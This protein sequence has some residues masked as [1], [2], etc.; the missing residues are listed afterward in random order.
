L[1]CVGD[2]V[3]VTDTD[4]TLIYCS[5]RLERIFANP[6]SGLLGAKIYD[7]VAGEQRKALRS[8][9]EHVVDADATGHTELMADDGRPLGQVVLRRVAL[10]A[11]GNTVAN[12]ATRSALGAVWSFTAP[13]EDAPLRLSD[14]P[15][16]DAIGVC[17]VDAAGR[18]EFTN[19]PFDEMVGRAAG[20]LAGTAAIDLIHLREHRASK[21]LTLDRLLRRFDAR[22]DKRQVAFRRRDGN[23]FAGEVLL[24]RIEQNG[25]RKTLIVIHDLAERKRLEGEIV[26]AS[27]RERRR[28]GSDLHDGLGQE[29][30]GI[31]LL[32]RGFARQI[33]PGDE[34]V[35]GQLNGIIGL[36][37]HAVESTR[38]LT[39][40]LSPA[41]PTRED[42]VAALGSLAAWS[43]S[44]FGIQVHVRVAVPPDL[45]IEESHAAHL[46]LIAQEAILNAV[47]HG[48]AE[49][50][51]L[52][53]RAGEQ[54][55]SLTI[56]DN[57][58]G[59]P[60]EPKTS[61]G[62]GM[63]IMAYRA[64]MIGG[65]VH[66]KNRKSGG[67]RVRCFYAQTPRKPKAAKLAR[68]RTPVATS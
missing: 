33:R 52:S 30:T 28:L 67:T 41:T 40:G 45:R 60:P 53:F 3:A 14:W 34:S 51:D 44:N 46:Y 11:Q 27:S 7:L 26:E 35:L 66:F 13:T 43:R 59:L 25:T 17:L 64:G 58:I 18:I 63:K 32:L 39:L 37:N 19:P 50:I 23:L 49:A 20:E 2:G 15:Q 57:G 48:R 5:S 1:D 47:K 36:V 12:A 6:R 16:R 61:A 68:G 65:S 42:F 21:Q 22:K 10:A 4:G 29:L 56:A 9:H 8:L 38:T 31:A 54:L 24:S 62:L 55:V